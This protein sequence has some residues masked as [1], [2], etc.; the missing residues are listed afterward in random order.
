M[1]GD[2]L[3]KCIGLAWGGYQVLYGEGMLRIASVL[4]LVMGVVTTAGWVL[5]D[6][7]PRPKRRRSLERDGN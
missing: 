1:L 2:G 7:R 4:L 3:M 6:I 5:N